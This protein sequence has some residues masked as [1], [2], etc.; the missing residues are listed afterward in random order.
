MKKNNQAY[1]K[2]VISITLIIILI[3][4]IFIYKNSDEELLTNLDSNIEVLVRDAN[5]LD[6]LTSDNSSNN[7]DGIGQE[8][9]PATIED[10]GGT[11]GSGSLDQL[12]ENKEI[13]IGE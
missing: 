3:T 4:L 6:A 11:N 13:E 12:L 8:L 10:L 5:E 9:S 7:T 2:I 1:F